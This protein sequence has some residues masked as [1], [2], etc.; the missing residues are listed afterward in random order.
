MGS[1]QVQKLT[2]GYAGTVIVR[3]LDLHVDAGEVVVLM[4]R[5]G[6]G[7]ST[8]LGAIAGNLQGTNGTVLIDGDPLT[9]PPYRRAGK[10]LGYVMEGR[11]VFQSLTVRK[12]FEVAGAP[13]D[14]ATEWFPE[15]KPFLD[16]PAGTLSGGE[17]Q[18]VA[19]GRALGQQPSVLLVDELSFGLAP[20]VFHRLLDLLRASAKA[21]SMA[22]LVVEQHLELA[23]G[24]ADRALIMASGEIALEID[25]HDLA[26]RAA[27]VER[28][29][30]GGPELH[31]TAI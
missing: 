3:D 11:S 15:L 29:Y 5:N 18:M 12:N 28:L 10:G 2:A 1:L 21:K 23:I 16:R 30:L 9:G 26:R 24:L 6:V 25:G 27:E 8:T 20:I 13:L 22:I 19:L 17:Q 14:S 7:K 31:S 4:G